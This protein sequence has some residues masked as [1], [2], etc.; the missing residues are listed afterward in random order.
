[1]REGSFSLAVLLSDVHYS[2]LVGAREGRR[3]QIGRQEGL[4]LTG[5]AAGEAHVC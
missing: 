2:F 4:L 1:M 3:I 5:S